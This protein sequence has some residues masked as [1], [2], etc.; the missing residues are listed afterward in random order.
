[1]F[2]NK[3]FTPQELSLFTAFILSVPIATG[4][5]I[6]KPVW[7]IALL[8]FIVIFAGSYGLILFTL[9]NFIYRKIK[10]IYKL[11]YQTKASKKEEFY[12]KNLLPQKGIEEVRADVESWAR[13]KKQEVEI[14]RKNEAFRKE[15]LQNLGHELRTPVFAIQGYVETLLNGALHNEEVNTKFLQNTARNVERLVNLLDDLDEISSLE[16][17][18]VKLHQKNFIIQDLVLEVFESLD[19]HLREKKI[20]AFIKKG[21]ESPLTVYADK[22]KIRQVITNLIENSIKYGKMEGIIEASFYNLDGN[23][24]LTEISDNGF[25][26]AED[27]LSRLFERFYRTDEARAR[28]TGGS[29][30]G[31]SI[32]KHIIEAHGQTIHVRSKLDVGTTFGFTLS[33][34]VS[35]PE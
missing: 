2:R 17:G 22:E 15:F 4:I 19:I 5:F 14:L 10:L 7:W 12:Y 6:F 13:Q 26:I 25:G 32:C 30:L 16:S 33:T 27:Q 20:K 18:Q 31:L 1:M 11:I 3:S 34:K 21:C 9:Q 28:R 35:A 8:S 23:R 24:V 29:G